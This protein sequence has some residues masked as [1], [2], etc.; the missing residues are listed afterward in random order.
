VGALWVTRV[1]GSMLFQ[2]SV[3]DPAAF[4]AA[5]LLLLVVAIGAAWFPARRATRVDPVRALS[6]VG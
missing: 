6:A 5:G 2:V 3:R 4:T 1:L